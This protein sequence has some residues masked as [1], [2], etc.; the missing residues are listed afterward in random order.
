MN[1]KTKVAGKTGTLI[2]QKGAKVRAGW[3]PAMHAAVVKKFPP[4]TELEVLPLKAVDEKKIDEIQARLADDERRL[5]FDTTAYEGLLRE[6]IKKLSDY[7]ITGTTPAKALTQRLE[8]AQECVVRGRCEVASKKARLAE[9][10]GG[11]IA[12]TLKALAAPPKVIEKPVVENP[13]DITWLPMPID[14]LEACVM[15]APDKDVRFYLNGVFIQSEKQ[16]VRAVATNGHS[17]L[18]HSTPVAKDEKLPA[19]MEA[20][21]ILPRE[22]L[23]LALATIG[24]LK[25]PRDPEGK[26]KVSVI[27]IGYAKGHAH[28]TIKD[29]DEQVVFRMRAI[30][31]K[32]PDYRKETE[33]AARMLEGG[34]RAP[35]TANSLEGNYV[36]QAAAIGA[37][38]G[39]KGLT[40]FIGAEENARAVIAFLGVPEA[41]YIL[42]P[43][44]ASSAD[45]MPTAT[46][47]LMGRGL[48]GTLAALKATQT[49]QKKQMGDEKSEAVKKQMLAVITERDQR[50]AA[51]L[52]AMNGKAL[53]APKAKPAAPTSTDKIT[54]KV[55]EAANGV[56]G[57]PE[58][59]AI[60]ADVQQAKE[61]IART[62]N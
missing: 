5:A 35:M 25:D 10:Q 39:A 60:A 29:G 37:K 33:G 20:G 18:L 13:K 21:V 8:Q 62:A 49:R 24:K 26:M 9:I 31:G 48:M 30:D 22:G 38:L 14:V 12:P 7:A 55:I 34:E 56:D 50:I 51:V 59:Q 16:S 57:D 32:F 28:L 41:L 46:L 15:V 19:W 42:M 36:K 53:E 58:I 54:A 17:L 3:T 2:E 45:Q 1:A 47:A 43:I 23:A 27:E 4:L 52:Q 44:R 11:L 61:E 6:G 40:P